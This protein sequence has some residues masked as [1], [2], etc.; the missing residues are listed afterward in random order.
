VAPTTS[1]TPS[2][3]AEA[4][5]PRIARLGRR[6]GSD[7]LLKFSGLRIGSAT[8]GGSCP[9]FM[10]TRYSGSTISATAEPQ[11]HPA[12]LVATSRAG[13]DDGEAP[14]SRKT[15]CSHEPHWRCCRRSNSE[16]PVAAP[17][18]SGLRGI[19]RSGG[20]DESGARVPRQPSEA[21]ARDA[22]IVA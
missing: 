6:A 9:A 13:P 11:T 4:P 8:A 14:A 17:L 19:Q 1:K 21:R 15:R 12:S 10:R 3:S 16:A 22:C 7:L 18:M 20:D 2:A 5:F